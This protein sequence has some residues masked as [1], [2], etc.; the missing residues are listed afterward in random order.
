MWSVQFCF[1]LWSFD[2]LT[3]RQFD[4]GGFFCEMTTNW[5][6][7]VD[8]QRD[9]ISCS[10]F[11][12]S[13]VA[14]L[15]HLVVRRSSRMSSTSRSFIFFCRFSV[16]HKL[17]N[18]FPIIRCDVFL[19]YSYGRRR[20]IPSEHSKSSHM[21]SYRTPRF[22]GNRSEDR[23]NSSGLNHVEIRSTIDDRK[24]NNRSPKYRIDLF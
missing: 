21:S 10:L 19:Q 7:S 23:Q 9:S 14:N 2:W 17:L 3:D 22:R 1:T 8:D 12:F 5:L 18:W 13:S 24:N 16:I 15:Q 20:G 6:R 11:L 4:F